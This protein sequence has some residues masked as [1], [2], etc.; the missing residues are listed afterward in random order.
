[1]VTLDFEEVYS[2]FFNKIE[3]YDFLELDNATIED[4]LLHYLLSSFTNP[5]VR[6]LF[7]TLNVDEDGESFS[8]EMN[9]PID[10]Y[11]DKEFIKE[12]LALGLCIKWITPRVNSVIGMNQ[13]YG[14][15]EEKYFSESSHKAELRNIL[16][17]WK[18]EQ[19]QQIRDRGYIWNNYLDGDI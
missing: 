16:H 19:L 3:A 15:K 13:T 17:L 4:M 2:I 7:S 1:M 6:Q 8:F 18:R 10:D 5:F 11:T 14:S 12:V 9:Y